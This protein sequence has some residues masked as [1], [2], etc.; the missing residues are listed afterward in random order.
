MFQDKNHRSMLYSLAQREDIIERYLNPSDI[1]IIQGYKIEVFA[2]DLNS[3]IGMVFN[4]DGDILIADAGLATGNPRVLKLANNQFEI[5]ADN[6]NIPISGINY[7]N[8]VIYVSHRGF[9]TKVYKDGTKQNII[10]GLPSNGDNYNSPVTFSP[11]SKLYFGQGTVTNAGVVGT[12]NEW[13]TTSPL[14]CDYAGD[15]IMLYGQNYLTNNIF[16][17]ALQEDTALT[18]AF[19]PYG[20]ANLPYETRK[21]YIKA[22]GSVLRANLDGSNLEQVAW[23][24][25]NPSYLKFDNNGQLFASNNGYQAIGSRPIENATDDFYYVSPGLWYG[26]PDYSGGEAVNS[27]RFTPRGGTQ[28]FA[29]S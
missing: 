26:W 9:V 13:V 19:S 7:L 29:C 24:F 4:D 22:S 2:K 21:Q 18:G 1:Y 28:P 11:D 6:F 14:L 10:M 12:D 17:E 5:I 23:G 20:I 27:A 25:R 3:P 16:T 15:H 8:G